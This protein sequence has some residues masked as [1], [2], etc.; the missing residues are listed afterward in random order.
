[1]RTVTNAHYIMRLLAFSYFP[2][3]F[4]FCSLRLCYR[5]WRKQTESG[6]WNNP[7]IYLEGETEPLCHWSYPN[8]QYTIINIALCFNFAFVQWCWWHFRFKNGPN[9][10]KVT[11]L[12]G[13]FVFYLFCECRRPTRVKDLLRQGDKKK[14]FET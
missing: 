9:I 1:M 3:Q 13:N 5:E 10:S 12:R 4:T 2:P 6:Q 11:L 8:A 14:P 7:L